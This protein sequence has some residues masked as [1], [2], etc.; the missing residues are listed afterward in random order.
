MDAGVRENGHETMTLGGGNVQGMYWMERTLSSIY[1][2]SA[3]KAFE[4]DY[5]P[6]PFDLYPW[7]ESWQCSGLKLF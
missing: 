4:F 2:T 7:K 5:P 6:V 3:I 1:N